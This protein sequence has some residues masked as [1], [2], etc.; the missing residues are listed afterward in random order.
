MLYILPVFKINCIANY[1]KKGGLAQNSFEFGAA[2]F[3]KKIREDMKPL[4]VSKNR[5]NTK[6][7]STDTLYQYCTPKLVRHQ[8]VSSSENF[9]LVCCGVCVA[10]G[11]SALSL[12]QYI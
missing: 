11:S 8:Y 12:L 7:C 10:M 9:A 6:A 5:I 1:R 3:R 2:F 4:A